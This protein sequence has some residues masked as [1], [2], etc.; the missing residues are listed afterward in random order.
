MKLEKNNPV[1]LYYQLVEQ[2]REQIRSGE[3]KGDEKL[4][5]ELALSKRAGVSR[6]TARQAIAYLAREG[7]LTVKPGV[8]TFVAEPKLT[9]DALHLL[10]FT[11]EMM[12]QGG[13]VT[14]NVLE[15]SVVTA[16]QHVAT[17]LN[18]SPEG[19]AVKIVRLRQADQV[20][21]LLETSFVPAALCPGLEN[22]DLTDKSLYELMERRYGLYPK[23]ARQTFEAEVASEYE[24][25]LFGVEAGTA[26]IL[27]EG[28]NYVDLDLPVEYFRAIYRGDRFKF[29]VESQRDGRVDEASGRPR[30][31]VVLV[32]ERGPQSKDGDA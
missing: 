15:Q 10:G 9:Y 1:P 5:S 21:L 24:Q 27:L 6:M 2:I 20:P 11:E 16:P 29:A 30:V 23:R 26:M 7:L 22:E 31:S 32:G 8:G 14:S 19:K 17:E 18:L 28:V 12:Q 3:L 25:R 4:P 13:M